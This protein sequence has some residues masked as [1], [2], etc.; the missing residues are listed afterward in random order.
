MRVK[1]SENIKPLFKIAKI[2]TN[3]GRIYEQKEFMDRLYRQRKKRDR[4][5]GFRV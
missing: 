3:G 4:A 1:E 5:A 2:S